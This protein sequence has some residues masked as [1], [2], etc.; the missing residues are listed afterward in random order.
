VIA[1]KILKWNSDVTLE[2]HALGTWYVTWMPQCNRIILSAPIYGDIMPS[3][4]LLSFMI[5][6]GISVYTFELH[7]LYSRQM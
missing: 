7:N 5:T 4:Y 1:R 2:V 6:T 3:I